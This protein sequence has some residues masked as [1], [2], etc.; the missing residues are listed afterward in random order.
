M[1]G[2][3]DLYLYSRTSNF[4]TINVAGH[5]LVSKCNQHNRE[6]RICYYN[7]YIYID[8]FY[9]NLYPYVQKWKSNKQ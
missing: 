5:M 6:E 4:I 2:T 3:N 8:I 9:N 7:N 1:F